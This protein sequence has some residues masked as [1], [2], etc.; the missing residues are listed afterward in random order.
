V[1]SSISPM[2]NPSK[3]QNSLVVMNSLV[4]SISLCTQTWFVNTAPKNKNLKNPCTNLETS[5]WFTIQAPSLPT[6]LG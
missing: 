3:S 1:E 2:F 6:S 4:G 5:W